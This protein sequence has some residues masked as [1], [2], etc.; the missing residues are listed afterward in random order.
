MS[1]LYNELVANGF[2][3]ELTFKNNSATKIL[4]IE[5]TQGQNVRVTVGGQV[6]VPT[7]TLVAQN[8]SLKPVTNGV[9]FHL[10][11]VE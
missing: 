3:P 2:H 5:N 8:P 4:Y 11:G 6:N 10:S 9:R 1:A 7:F